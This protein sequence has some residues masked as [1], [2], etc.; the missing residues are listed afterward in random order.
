ML[1]KRHPKLSLTEQQALIHNAQHCSPTFQELA[2]VL[3]T[4]LLKREYPTALKIIED[5][6]VERI[7][8]QIDHHNSTPDAGHWGAIQVVENLGS[9]IRELEKRTFVKELGL[10]KIP[11]S[12]Q[13]SSS[14]SSSSSSLPYK[15]PSEF[16]VYAHLQGPG[17]AGT[18]IGR[19]TTRGDTYTVFYNQ[20]IIGD[21]IEKQN[22]DRENNSKRISAIFEEAKP[23]GNDEKTLAAARKIAEQ[24][25]TAKLSPS[26]EPP[27][28]SSTKGSVAAGSGLDSWGGKRRRTRKNLKRKRNTRRQRKVQFYY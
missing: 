22:A 7:I 25:R 10:K 12:V 24:V 18:L 20:R 16:T 15:V 2:G 11:L 3:T 4:H 21:K 13:A 28:S 19:A 6:L 14:S 27:A 9:V 26:A 8:E 23:L 17:A 5:C 1:S